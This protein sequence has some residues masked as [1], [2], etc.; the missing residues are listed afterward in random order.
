MLTD[1][2]R[3]LTDPIRFVLRAV[4]VS[5]GGF[6]LLRLTWTERISCCR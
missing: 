3:H 2:A 5:L 1:T 4:A 6:G